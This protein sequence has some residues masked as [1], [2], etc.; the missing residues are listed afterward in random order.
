LAS[1]QH[2]VLFP[3]TGRKQRVAGIRK[4]V[5]RRYPYLVYYTADDGAE[6]VVMRSDIRLA[7]A[8][9]LMSEVARVE[10]SRPKAAALP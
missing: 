5:T 4:L 2:L 1:L 8:Q 6:E 3:K 7:N 10:G 9:I